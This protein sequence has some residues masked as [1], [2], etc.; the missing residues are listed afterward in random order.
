MFVKGKMQIYSVNGNLF[1]ITGH[2]GEKWNKRTLGVFP[3]VFLILSSFAVSRLNKFL[4][5]GKQRLSHFF[6]LA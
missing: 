2:Y 1:H 6:G 5:R 3:R 4:I